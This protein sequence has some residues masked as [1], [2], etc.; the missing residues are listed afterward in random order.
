M[1]SMCDMNCMYDLWLWVNQEHR[2]DAS[3]L[4]IVDALRGGQV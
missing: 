3:L 4:A 2:S 1:I